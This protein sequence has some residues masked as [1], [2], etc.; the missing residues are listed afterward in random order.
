MLMT[1][2]VG[3]NFFDPLLPVG[4]PAQH[5]DRIGG[6]GKMSTAK[7]K[8][9]VCLFG[10]FQ[11]CITLKPSRKER[12]L[13]FAKL[14]TWIRLQDWLL[15]GIALV[16]KVR[17]QNLG[18]FRNSFYRGNK[19]N[20]FFNQKQPSENHN[21]FFFP[22]IHRMLGHKPIFKVSE[23]LKRVCNNERTSF[24]FLATFWI[25]V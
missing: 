18:A 6:K 23:V 3:S 22:K 8:G 1:R 25:S 17:R 5:K 7:T 24:P 14:R 13:T 4:K 9:G 11:P 16:T 12:T 2:R 21:E 20:I 10:V 15:R 19:R